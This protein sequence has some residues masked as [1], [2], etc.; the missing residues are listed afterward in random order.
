MSP[1][2]GCSFCLG[3]LAQGD[4]PGNLGFEE[5][6]SIRPSFLEFPPHRL[7]PMSDSPANQPINEV[8][9]L[10]KTPTRDKAITTQYIYIYIYIY[11]QAI[12][13][14]EVSTLVTI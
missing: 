3:R 11:M 8:Y 4:I 1:R 13:E 5:A 12:T 2:W 7:P 10:L 9:A 14:N 6:E